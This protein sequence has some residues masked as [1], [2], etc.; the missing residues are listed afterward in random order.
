[1]NNIWRTAKETGA[2]VII[3]V[4]GALHPNEDWQHF[5]EN[6]ACPHSQTK[7]QAWRNHVNEWIDTTE[8]RRV[9]DGYVVPVEYDI[10]N[11]PDGLGGWSHHACSGDTDDYFF[12]V[13]A[14]AVDVIRGRFPN[15][16][17]S[18][19][20]LSGVDGYDGV[21]HSAINMITFMDWTYRHEKLPNVLSW[22]DIWNSKPWDRDTTGTTG[23]K[24]NLYAQIN[25]A[26]T[27]VQTRWVGVDPDDIQFEINEM[28]DATCAQIPAYNVR[29]F[30]L[31]ERAKHD[32]LNI[33]L[34]GKACWCDLCQ[35]CLC[36][37]CGYI[38]C[39]R[40][41]GLLQPDACD[42]DSTNLYQPR[43]VWWAFKAYADISG[44]YV[45]ASSPDT[46]DAIAGVDLSQH[47]I[48]ILAG[49][50]SDIPQESS[51]IV[52]KNVDPS[53]VINQAIHAH[54]TRILGT[55]ESLYDAYPGLS[56]TFV[57]SSNY[58]VE[59]DSV[60]INISS[61]NFAS[62]DALDIQLTR[63]NPVNTIAPG[64]FLTVQAA[65]S[66]SQ[67]GNTIVV[68]P[69]S[70]GAV[71]QE[72][73]ILLKNGVRVTSLSESIPMIQGLQESVFV[74]PDHANAFTSLERVEAQAGPSTKVLIALRGLGS[75]ENCTL[76]DMGVSGVTGLLVDH[77]ANA[78]A[79]GVKILGG[80]LANGINVQTATLSADACT[81]SAANGIG[82][83]F[84]SPSNSSLRNS[85]ITMNGGQ[86]TN[87]GVF[88]D[89]LQ[90]TPI[91]E[92]CMVSVHGGTGIGNSIAGA[93]IKGCTIY[94][95]KWGVNAP[96][97]DVHQCIAAQIDASGYGFHTSSSKKAYYCIAPGSNGFDT[98]SKDPTSRQED[99]LFCSPS[100]GQFTLRIDSYGNPENPENTSHAQI[101]AF[102]VA[103]AYGDLVRDTEFSGT[104]FV[105]RDLRVP[106]GRSLTLHPGA[107][108][109]IDTLDELNE[110]FVSHELVEIGV[111]GTLH[112]GQDGNENT[113]R[114]VSAATL[115]HAGDWFGIYATG[116]GSTN[117]IVLDHADIE[118]SVY[119]LLAQTTG[120]GTPCVTIQHSLFD[121]NES[122]SMHLTTNTSGAISIQNNE[123]RVHYANG[124]A[125]FGPG[126]ANLVIDSN[127]FAG[128]LGLTNGIDVELSGLTNQLQIS[129]NTFTG[130]TMG[131][132]IKINFS[133][134]FYNIQ[135]P[136]I[137]G[138]TFADS[139]YGVYVKTGSAYVGGAT[140]ELGNVFTENG[141]P[142]YV[143]CIGPGTCRTCIDPEVMVR[144]NQFADTYVTQITTTKTTALNA[145]HSNDYGNNSLGSYGGSYC[146]KNNAYTCG[147]M[148]A[149]GNYFA[150][151]CN[152]GFWCA[153]Q[154]VLA[155]P[156]ICDD[157]FDP[158][159]VNLTIGV[160]GKAEKPS[161]E[162]VNLARSGTIVE[163]ELR[164]IPASLHTEV[165]DLS[166]RLERDLGTLEAQPGIHRLDWDG[167]NGAGEE[168][169][170]GIHFIRISSGTG[171]RASA[172]A[173]ILKEG[174]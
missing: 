17:I 142:I 99:P 10:W 18:G 61:G 43:Y 123:F 97:G 119:G 125:L 130:F 15:A 50:V 65:I 111:A 139:H 64:N 39:G 35:S 170:A 34:V 75:V 67:P 23:P 100:E 120:E 136:L 128:G 32:G 171:L 29:E 92:D 127:I 93:D 69:D 108:L 144:R 172:K 81:V 62:G 159:S 86:S 94:D 146:I 45:R 33:G 79:Q 158:S 16:I 113:V 54:I 131:N 103:C 44:D 9:V 58:V 143:E 48:R 90:G 118:H 40:L 74:F 14:A 66:A 1:M 168:V 4:E 28:L 145:G 132:C 3:G 129:N 95:V 91:I 56:P 24:R 155:D 49:R 152:T 89:Y 59:G 20:A 154:G 137:T 88:C 121:N 53:M 96:L 19:P 133:S 26:R 156:P 6:D 42:G 60:V 51:R 102:P 153:N 150:G 30:A 68:V 109:N 147:A 8:V 140:N 104:A 25:H 71:Y 106:S 149:V 148:Y 37:T 38:Q 36:A 117:Q 55:P 5:W 115:P 98:N 31:A 27:L 114:F 70:N 87:Y 83:L 57:D 41:G 174:R 112:V 169:G 105:P 76:K 122:W 107:V 52:I 126:T 141:W 22:H 135:R 47:V 85:S 2:T 161:L 12:T 164:G 162:I 166:G 134:G 165:F 157:P 110:G 46:I 160:I 63:I 11:E 116:V 73:K 84:Y 13:W 80:N 21:N 173:L 163:F 101:G 124:V 78:T 77:G 151:S 138:N 72:N 167:R 7:L 82:V